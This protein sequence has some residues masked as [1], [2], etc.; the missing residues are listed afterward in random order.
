MALTSK[1]LKGN[2]RLDSAANGGPPLRELP[3]NDDPEAV[4]RLQNALVA[5]GYQSYFTA[6]SFPNGFDSDPDGRFGQ[7][8]YN[9]VMAFQRKKAFPGNPGQWDGRAGKNTLAEMDKRLPDGGRDRPHPDVPPV[10]PNVDVK[11]VQ[12][13]PGEVFLITARP[14]NP[15]ADDLNADD[16]PISPSVSAT[17]KER[18]ENTKKESTFELEVKMRTE[19]SLGAADLGVAFF[20]LFKFNSVAGQEKVPGADFD[21]RVGSGGGFASGHAWFKD[22]V[23]RNLRAQFDAGLVDYHDLVTGN[24]LDRK[25]GEDVPDTEPAKASGRTLPS[26][27]SPGFQIGASEVPLK[28]VVGSWQGHHIFISDF[29]VSREPPS[30]SAK[31]IY[32][33]RDHFGANDS[34]CEVSKSLHGT[35]GQLSLWVLQ[36]TRHDGGTHFPFV[37]VARVVKEISGSLR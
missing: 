29:K 27:E 6:K 3:Q 33:L 15:G 9:A 37:P 28:T 11:L 1:I 31:L 21:N 22:R 24:G 30:Y 18:V 25:F 12:Q 36:H 13:P 35:P 5:L 4:K 34:D 7:E 10:N 20:S 32:E 14:H 23:E 2:P 17:A 19:L 26:I 8:T 16:R